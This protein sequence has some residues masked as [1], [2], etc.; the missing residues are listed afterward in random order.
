MGPSATPWTFWAAANSLDPKRTTKN[1]RL[2]TGAMLD[3]ASK[4]IG[5]WPSGFEEEE[6]F[7][8][9]KV[10]MPHGVSQWEKS[11]FIRISKR[12]WED[13]KRRS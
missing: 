2:K 6:D 13:E 5:R 7:E 3:S 4:R 1:K 12:F 10:L 9:P 11:G 8:S